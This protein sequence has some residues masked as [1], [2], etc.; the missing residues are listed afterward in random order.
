VL[1]Y[2]KRA[3]WFL[4]RSAGFVLAKLF[5]PIWKILVYFSYKI[6]YFLRRLGVSGQNH[7]LF[8]RDNLQVAIFVILFFLV[9]PQTILYA[10]KDNVLYGQRT[11]AYQIFGSEEEYS[12][13]EIL[14]DTAPVDFVSSPSW[15]QGALSNDFGSGLS[16]NVMVRDQDFGNLVAGGTALVKPNIIPGAVLSGK[17][18]NAIVYEVQPGDSLSSI[19]YQFGVSVATVMWENNLSLKSILKLNQKLSILPTTG[20]MHTVKKG[21]TVIK[22][23]KLYGVKEADVVSYNKLSED[24]SGLKIGE[25]LMVPNG[26]KEQTL[27]TV[28]RAVASVTSKVVPPSSNQGASAYGFVW[29]SSAKII[30]QYYNWAHHAIDIAGPFHSANYA[31]KSGKVVIS[32]CGWN[33]GYGCYIVIDHGGG[34][35]TLYGHND[36]LLVSPGDYVE[37]GQTI[38]LMGNTGKVRGVTGI[39]LHFEIQI[40]G[41]RVNPLGY[42]R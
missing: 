5:S 1:V 20:V 15:R 39:H 37:A 12:L 35:R 7:W 14:A 25:R 24:G 4:G 9:T 18:S 38:G 8:K 41:V 42:V 36:K 2:L 31:A 22:I 21:D 17:R 16:G 6:N 30:T 13:E 26:V 23:A 27:A 28:S 19:A 34:V 11:I 3:L 10:K 40:N 29:P 32:Q 33:S